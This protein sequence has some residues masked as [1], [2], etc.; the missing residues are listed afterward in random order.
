MNGFDDYPFWDLIAEEAYLPKSKT[1]RSGTYEKFQSLRSDRDIYMFGCNDACRLFL[2]RFGFRWHF[3]GVLDNAPEKWGKSFCGLPVLEPGKV[4]PGLDEERI[5]IIIAMRMHT[6]DVA[7]QLEELGFHTY[8]GLGVLLAGMEPYRETVEHIEQVKAQP[9]EDMV[10]LEST[11]DFDGNAG[12]LYEYLKSRGS[13]YRFVWVIKND[14]NRRFL[15]DQRDDV[16]CPRICRAELE[17]YLSYR[18]RAKWQIWDNHPIRKVR[19][20]QI[21]VFLQHFGMGYKQI[22]GIFNSPEYVDYALNTN[23]NVYAYEKQALLY[24]PE[25]RMIFGQLPR[26]DVLFMDGWDELSKITDQKYDKYV[27]WAPTLRE[28]AMFNRKDSDLEYPYGVSL[29]YREEDV[30]RLNEYLAER[31]MLM[32]MKIHPRQKCNYRDGRYSNILYLDSD[33]VKKVHP[34]KLMTQMDAMVT[35]YSSIAFDY[36]LLDKPMAWVLE[37]MGSY[38]VPFL[39]DNPLDFMPG[40]QVHTLA[41]LIEFLGQVSRGEDPYRAERNALSTQYNA[42]GEERGCENV[43]RVLG[44]L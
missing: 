24:A 2:E 7:V 15:A 41:Q 17:K 21:N 35:D 32:L 26:N 9:L 11:N 3:A 1:L 37:D 36:M 25:T 4:L 27:M 23:E 43:A 22:A 39:M 30:R 12:A 33:T 18:A 34:Y 5:A 16:V 44:L 13:G 42:P 28:S 29:L 8:Y 19:D 6:D 20:G 31:D 10:M 40:N 38:K 14:A